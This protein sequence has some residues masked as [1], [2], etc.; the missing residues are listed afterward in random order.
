MTS[1]ERIEQIKSL[2]CERFE[3]NEQILQYKTRFSNTVI[4]RQIAMCLMRENIKIAGVKMGF[5]R[6]GSCF[7]LNHATALHACKLFNNLPDKDKYKKILTQLQ[8]Q[9]NTIITQ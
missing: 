8:E 6:I 4:P 2:V 9:L 1:Q 5:K 7:G 3:I